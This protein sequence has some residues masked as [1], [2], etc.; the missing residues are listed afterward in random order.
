MTALKPRKYSF[1]ERFVIEQKRGRSFLG[2]LFTSTWNTLG[3]GSMAYDATDPRNSSLRGQFYR[4]T[5]HADLVNNIPALRNICRSFE[6]NNS[7]VRAIVEGLVANVIGSGIGLEP[8]T[9]DDEVND[10]IRAEWNKYIR[11]CGID[12]TG[13]YQLQQVA[14]RDIVIGGEALARLVIEEDRNRE[15]KIPLAILP[16]EPEWLGGDGMT[17]SAQNNTEMGG[18][19]LDDYGRPKAYRLMS[20]QG[21]LEEIPA[22]MVLHAFERRRSMQ[23][24]G[25]PWLA[26]ILTTLRQEKDLVQIELEA[27]KNSSAYAVAIMTP[28]GQ[29]SEMDEMGRAVRNIQPGTVAELLPGE[30][31]QMLQSNRPAQQ[32]AEFRKM[33]RG[34][35]AAACKLGQRWLDRDVS[36]ANYSSMRADMLDQEKLIG[37]CREWFGHQ[38]VGKL[39]KAVLPYLALKAGVSLPSSDYRLI[40]DGQPYVDPLKDAQ[41]GAMAIAFGLSTFEEECG[42]RGKDWKQVMEQK[43]RE[44][45]FADSL[46]LSIQTPAGI[47]VGEDGDLGANADPGGEVST[48]GIAKGSRPRDKN[49][50]FL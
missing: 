16:L 7:T 2:A 13:L 37:P 22:R 45:E 14:F 32:I 18:V 30:Q 36:G 50:H 33:L 15:K 25:E 34:D 26:P 10:K 4:P 46:D 35:E 47:M 27:A 19:I 11:Y 41:A 12:G 17:L 44:E 3:V 5:T 20:P 6:R 48:A 31:I 39:Y 21:I 23:V 43:K 1:A 9:G 38:Y 40:P 24:R 42:K 8:D 28:G 29:A 49:G